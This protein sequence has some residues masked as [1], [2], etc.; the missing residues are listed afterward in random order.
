[1]GLVGRTFDLI[2]PI[3]LEPFLLLLLFG[4]LPRL[5]GLSIF[6]QVCMILQVLFPGDISGIN[7]M[8]D[9]HPI[10]HRFTYNSCAT[11]SWLTQHRISW[12]TSID[13]GSCIGRVTQDLDD[14]RLG[15]VFPEDLSF[16]QPAGLTTG[17]QDLVLLEVAQRLHATAQFCK[18]R[19]DQSNDPPN[20][21]IWIKFNS[22]ILQTDQSVGHFL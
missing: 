5:H 14:H 17:Y 21:I 13:E 10:L 7:S 1:M 6:C 8:P 22:P 15:G 12:T 9:G 16:E 18:G 3:L 11:L 20:L 2:T 4:H 19:E